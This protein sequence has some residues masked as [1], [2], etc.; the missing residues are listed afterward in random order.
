MLR[1]AGEPAHGHQTGGGS[2]AA[3]RAVRLAVPRHRARGARGAGCGAAGTGGPATSGQLCASPFCLTAGQL[4]RRG[5][6]LDRGP[7]VLRLRAV[8]VRRGAL[9]EQDALPPRIRPLLFYE[10][11]WLCCLYVS[12]FAWGIGAVVYH[13]AQNGTLNL[14]KVWT[15][16]QYWIIFL[17]TWQFLEMCV[18]LRFH[19][20]NRKQGYQRYA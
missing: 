19:L 18:L 4:S 20:R 10:M 6:A 15:F 7:P 1:A 17:Y 16:C 2:R 5:P 11:C 9:S 13:L 8:R 12:W 3:E 14:A